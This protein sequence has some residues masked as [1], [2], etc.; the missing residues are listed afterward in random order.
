M[1]TLPT[2]REAQRRVPRLVTGLAACGTGLGLMVRARLG[3][4]PW[5][6]LHQGLSRHTGLQIGTVSILVG[7]LVLTGW[8]PLRQRLGLGTIANAVVIGLVTNEVLAL[9]PPAHAIAARVALMVAGIAVVGVGSGLYIGAGLGPGPRDG[10]MTGIA[11][12][13][14]SIGTA[15]TGLELCALAAGWL[16][17]GDV[18]VGTV[19]FA[20][21]IGPL[22]QLFLP[23][24]TIAPL[25]A[26]AE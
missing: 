2:A 23:R 4:G 3:L 9:V 20:V 8:I 14:P 7:M 15:R 12:R 18:G 21:G 16:L 6:V 11:A 10:L 13:G 17:G 25:T 5:E 24:L 19:L 26:P 1:L 22:V